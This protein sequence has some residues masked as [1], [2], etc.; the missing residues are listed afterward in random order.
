M[1]EVAAG[2]G[3]RLDEAADA[4]CCGHPS[5]G[6]VGSQFTAADTVYTACPACDANLEEA[7]VP[8]VPLWNALTGHARSAPAAACRS[9][10]PRIRALSVGAV[11]PTA[12]RPSLRSATRQSRPARR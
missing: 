5:R 1:H 10:G 4:G 11:S 12:T 6:A 2:F 7:G 9:S 8:T 3:V